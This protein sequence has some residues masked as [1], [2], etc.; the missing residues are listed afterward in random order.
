M[1]DFDRTLIETTRTHRERLTAAF[2][3]GRLTARQRVRTN[4]RRVLGSSIIAAVA[5]IACLATGFVVDT[6]ERQRNEQAVKAFQSAAAANPIKPSATLV[7]D[8]ATGF[9]VNQQTGQYIDPQT[10]FI[11]DPATMLATDP[12]GNLIDTRIDW[13]YDPATGYYTDP[14]SGITIDPKTLT[15]VGEDE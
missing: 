8:Q 4:L 6:L 11:V 7:E 15:V 2:V 12:Q 5:C 13:F 3:Y 1:S 14:A 9:L 10:G